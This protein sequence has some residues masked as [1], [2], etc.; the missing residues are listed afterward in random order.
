MPV[1]PDGDESDELRPADEETLQRLA[2]SGHI[3]DL[4]WAACWNATL[5]TWRLRLDDRT[6]RVITYLSESDANDPAVVD[7]T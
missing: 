1:N 6:R 2:Y 3:P 5:N 4:C 7:E